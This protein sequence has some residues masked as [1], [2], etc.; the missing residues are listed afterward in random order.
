MRPTIDRSDSG[1]WPAAVIARTASHA[2]DR[3]LLPL[4]DHRRGRRVLDRVSRRQVGLLADDDSVHRCGRLQP[5]G[6]VHHVAR[7]HRLAE[8]RPRAERDDGLARVDGDPDLQVAAGEL[9]D[10]VPDDER[11][12]H[13]ALR[14]VAVGER[15]AEH[16][17]HRVA[18]ELLDDAAE[19]LDLAADALVVGRKHRANLLGVEPL[20]PRR[21]P[22][23]VDEDDRDDPPLVPGRALVADRGAAR[24]A[25]VGDRRVLLAA[26]RTDDHW[27]SLRPQAPKVARILH[28]SANCLEMR[29]R[30]RLRAPM[31]PDSIDADP[32]SLPRSFRGY[33]RRATEELFRRVAWDYA[34]LA[35]EHRKLKPSAEA[36]PARRVAPVP[37]TS[38][39]RRRSPLAARRRAEGGA[40]SARVDPAECEQALRKAKGRAAEIE[41]EAERSA[42]DARAVLEAAAR[43]R[44]SLQRGPQQARE[45]AA[46]RG[47]APEPDRGYARC[48]RAEP[49]SRRRPRARVAGGEGVSRRPARR[50]DTGELSGGSERRRRSAPGARRGRS[51]KWPRAASRR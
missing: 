48:S 38:R 36:A 33:N 35:G 16:A 1:R 5:R 31:A 3:P 13:R 8:R 15:R 23:E 32:K 24:E 22:D 42:T 28:R 6:G 4:R 10:D 2:V 17:H 44:A 14:V 43:L 19:R 30:T 12:A 51:T 41:E 21:E 47:P 9:A 25:E 37:A 27:R 50:R 20:G 34:V 11:R 29:L 49:S 40:R 39:L 7:D 45:R 18:D 26:G 46:S